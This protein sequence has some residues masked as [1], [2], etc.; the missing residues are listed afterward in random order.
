M[1]I[2]TAN[3]E[4]DG[5]LWQQFVESRPEADNYHQW[6]WKQ[7]IERSFGWPTYY[8]MAESDGRIRGILPLVW[9]RSWAFGSFLTSL[10]FLN[11]G[12]VVAEDKEAEDALLQEAIAL[13]Q[14]LAARHLELRHRRDHQLGLPARTNKVAV[15]QPVGPDA[16]YLFR[17]LRPRVRTKI[18]KAEKSGLTAEFVGRDGLDDFYGVFAENMRDLGTPV[19]SRDFFLEIL[20]A[21][22]T[23]AHICV[24]RHQ[25]KPVAAS[26]LTGYRDT[27][28][29]GWIASVHKYLELGP[30]VFLYW[31]ML[32][33]AGERRYRILDFGRSTI[34]S[35]THRFK[36][37][38]GSQ[39]VALHWDYW[40][41]DASGLPQLNPENPR[42]RLAIWLWRKLPVG[43]TKL[44]GPRIVR[45]LP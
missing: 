1:R 7:V 24:I 11:G 14:S 33:F 44:A 36:M 25:G 6:G 39:E 42:Y 15:V 8:L 34:G 18:R 5:Q 31:K 32:C 27:L 23:Q 30:N 17:S 45:W 29:A 21:L 35:G 19:Y 16:E 43:V 12:G 37:Q 20:R 38:F 10:P 28:E 3:R 9:Q 26:L 13:A 4:E 40:L 22:P 2:V 41:Q